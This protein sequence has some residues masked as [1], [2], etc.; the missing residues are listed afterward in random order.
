MN[1]PR[2][3][4]LGCPVD[5]LDIK[6]TLDLIDKMVRSKSP[7]QHAVINVD[8]LLKYRSDHTLRDIIYNCDIIN[9]DGMPIVWAAKILGNPLKERIAGIDLMERLIELS[10]HKRYRL[11]FLGAKEDIV[12]EVFR[13]Y[14]ERFP[15]LQIAGFR[16]GYWKPEEEENV[17]EHIRNT[18][19]DILFIAMSSPKKEFFIKKYL[20]T[21]CVPFVMGVGGSFD[22]VAGK[23]RRAPKWMQEIGLE[24]LFRLLQ[25]PRRLWRRYL[26]G[27]TVVIYLVFKELMKKLIAHRFNY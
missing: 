27:N 2:V 23:I 1:R 8:K 21:M 20:H 6:E 24:W 25:E 26:V 19:A 15:E 11:F 4:I 5:N 7:H 22:V 9:A 18:R 17:V 13:I 12:N 3:N 10:V 14:R 16:N